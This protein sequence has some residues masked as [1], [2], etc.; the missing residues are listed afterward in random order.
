MMIYRDYFCKYITDNLGNQVRIE[1]DKIK[2]EV[3]K[4]NS[5]THRWDGPAVI[6]YH[7]DGTIRCKLWYINGN[8]LNYYEAPKHWPLSMEDQIALKFKHG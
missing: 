1:T 7:E 4:E 2:K 6:V 5:K 8:V 3:W